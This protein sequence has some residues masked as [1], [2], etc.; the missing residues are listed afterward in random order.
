MQA[1]SAEGIGGRSFHSQ[2]RPFFRGHGAA[3]PSWSPRWAPSGGPSDVVLSHLPTLLRS[4]FSCQFSVVSFPSS[5]YNCPPPTPMPRARS[6][7]KN[8]STANL[9]FEAKLRLAVSEVRKQHDEGRL[10]LIG[11]LPSSFLL[12]TFSV[13]ANGA[14][15]LLFSSDISLTKTQSGNMRSVRGT[16]GS[17]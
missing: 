17:M 10:V 12:H 7:A 14:L 5:L 2:L 8:N 15:R 6:S 3:S 13:L 16:S 1:R 4:H 9:G 11:L